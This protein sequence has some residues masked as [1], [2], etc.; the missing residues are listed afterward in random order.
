MLSCYFVTGRWFC[1]FLQFK[2]PPKSSHMPNARSACDVI[3]SATAKLQM[4]YPDAFIAISGDFN[5][6][7]LSSTP[8]T[9]L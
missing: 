8:H 4:D 2:S 3:H 1:H 5:H 6:A 9:S 7:T